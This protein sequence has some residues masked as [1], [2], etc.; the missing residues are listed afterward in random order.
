MAI[1]LNDNLD[2]AAAKAVDSR[3][4]PYASVAAALSAIGTIRRYRGLVLGVTAGNALKEYWF[5]DGILDTDL[6]EKQTGATYTYTASV[7][8]GGHRIVTIDSTGQ[9][10][11][12]DNTIAAHS[13][14]IA[15]MTLGAAAAGDVV[16]VQILGEHT[17]VSWNWTVNQPVFLST[18]GL[19]TQ[20]VPTTAGS[21]ILVI[22][23]ATAATK[24]FINIKPP[25]F[26]I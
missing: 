10:I 18:T 7:A 3:Y 5:K 15:G 20:T 13:N 9:A 12:A 25:I 4:G 6:V 24:M 21:Y 17:E 26:I 16:N 8:L 22:G 14:K 19:L 11:Y 1:L 23:T 2:I